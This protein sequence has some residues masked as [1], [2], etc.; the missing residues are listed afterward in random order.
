MSGAGPWTFHSSAR[1]VLVLNAGDAMSVRIDAAAHTLPSR[2]D[3]LHV[4]GQV[5]LA[6]YRLEGAVPLAACVIE[7]LPRA[8]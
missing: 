2:Y 4:E 3:C 1:T 7:L 6:E 5:G 8:A